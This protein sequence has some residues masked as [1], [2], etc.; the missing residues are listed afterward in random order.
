MNYAIVRRALALVA[1]LA[2]SW[3]NGQDA[4]GKA[5]VD[6][7]AWLA[8]TW[9][10]ERNGRE[11]TEQWMA[12]GGGTMLG[13]SRTVAKGAT[14]DHEFIVIRAD[15]DGDLVYVAK[16]ARQ[17]EVA[18]K[19]VRVSAHEAV[20]ENPAHD[21]PQRII[22]VLQA[23]GSLLAAIEGAKGGKTQRVEFPY[24]RVK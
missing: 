16:P 8:G 23:D 14:V 24:Q 18:F 7:L 13:V 11:V 17:P 3:A 2:A 15:E 4:P 9:R 1:G 19:L 22:Y 20:F 21:F 6:S 10:S 12:P 5:T